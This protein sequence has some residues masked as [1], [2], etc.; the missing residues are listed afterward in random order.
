MS[1]RK[2]AG[3]SAAPARPRLASGLVVAAL[4]VWAGIVLKASYAALGWPFTGESLRAL[5]CM[6]SP[7][8]LAVAARHIGRFGAASVALLSCFGVGRAALGSRGL[9]F[10]NPWEAAGLTLA[11]GQA[12]CGA[13][14]LLCGLAGILHPVPLAGLTGAAGLYG[15]V[16]LRDWLRRWRGDPSWL[17][18]W[19]RVHP[20]ASAALVAALAGAVLYELPFLLAPETFYDA[21]VYHL[22]LPN[23]YLIEHR[24]VPTPSNIYSG[25]PAIPQ[26]LY[27]QAMA[28]GGP[29]AARWVNAA[30]GPATGLLLA[31]IAVRWGLGGAGLW[32]AGFYLL[33]P[34]VLYESHRTSV[35]LAWGFFLTAAF[36]AL[37]AALEE[38]AGT[39][40]RRRWWIVAGLLAGT[41]MA[42]KYPAWGLPFAAAAAVLFH[43]RRAPAARARL[44]E[45]ALAVLAA[46]AALSP[47]L[48]KN[49]AF[50]GNPVYPYLHE[51]FTS[52]P[53]SR[54]G[55]LDLRR[56][57]LSAAEADWRALNS[58][59]NA[60]DLRRTVTTWDG[61]RDYLRHPWDF[62]TRAHFFEA[63][64][65]GPLFLCLV[66]LAFL[67][68]PAVPAY[69]LLALA[70]A[71]CWL[72]LSLISGMPRFFVPCLA[73]LSLLIAAAVFALGS[74]A[75]RSWIL[76]AA[77]AVCWGNLLV[78]AV[79]PSGAYLA[80]V[81]SGRVPEPEFL[82][83]GKTGYPT[84]PYAGIEFINRHAPADA[85][86]MLVGDPRG[87]YLERRYLA[88]SLF[89]AQD[90][91][92]V[93]NSSA[94][95]EDLVQRLRRAQVTHFLVNRGELARVRPSMYI[96]PQGKVNYDG[97][98]RRYTER[99][100]AEGTDL[101]DYRVLVYRLLSEEEAGRPHETDDLFRTA[102]N[103]SPL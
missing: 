62:S 19:P 94:S 42:T 71:A 96:S 101:N 50:Y 34:L 22:N 88:S 54:A 39:P 21:L 87:V 17:A 11:V 47:W 25:I 32:A 14:L 38:P 2:G 84:P 67:G 15:A 82:R 10:K 30:W 59:A 80:G 66:P 53:A 83:G 92:D 72:P 90:F 29:A 73:P 27:A 40:E 5:T 98:W 69:P 65:M 35:G 86:V 61:L 24:I 55:W 20:V 18:P 46:A 97:F 81:V 89:A 23:L 63:E 102:F 51:T 103:L 26:M 77:A 57:H 13:A 44:P 78:T 76:A 58:D 49:A 41:A 1:R 60:R 43:A 48:A 100:F 12:L 93:F 99:V 16:A 7:G 91:E 28:V 33:T 68:A 75:A 8:D 64:L 9:A 4:A 31:G 70:T 36:G 37:L 45:L 74:A 85:K 6:P 3:G 95:P 79:S 56:K 52:S